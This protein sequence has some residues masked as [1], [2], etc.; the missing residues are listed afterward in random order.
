MLAKGGR[1]GVVILHKEKG[2]RQIGQGISI[3]SISRRGNLGR[4][5]VNAVCLLDA[6]SPSLCISGAIDT[7]DTS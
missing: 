5:D 2:N 4:G 1:R 6:F 3:K 7:C